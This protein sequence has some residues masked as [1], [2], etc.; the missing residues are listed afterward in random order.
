MDDP[1][2]A[3]T[4]PA[5]MQSYMACGM[6]ILASASGETQRIIAQAD[7]GICCEIGNA[8]ALAD[9]VGS[10]MART[11]LRTLG[12]NAKAYSDRYFN[13]KILMD[14]MDGYLNGGFDSDHINA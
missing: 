14:E 2:W 8:E 10:L 13:K 4:I 7:C 1:L 11:D 3:K 12:N 9:A 5:K 6:P